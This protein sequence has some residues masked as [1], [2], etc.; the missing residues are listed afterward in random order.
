MDLSL[1]SIAIS[2]VINNNHASIELLTGTN[3]MK[4]KQDVEFGMGI[5]D[6]DLALQEDEPPKPN[7]R[8]TENEKA[9]YAKREKSNRLCLIAMKRSISEH[10]LSGLPENLNVKFF[11]KEVG[12]KYKVYDK[13]EA[14]NLVNEL[15]DL[16]YDA[17]IGVGEFILRMIHVQNKLKTRNIVFN[18]D[19]VVHHILNRLL[20]EFSQIKIA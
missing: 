16:R 9:Y 20:V 4:W 15:T 19:F 6:L 11:L 5:V 17:S 1:S 8:S 14:G 3:Y 13:A 10:L 7:E 12:E 18:D 2:F